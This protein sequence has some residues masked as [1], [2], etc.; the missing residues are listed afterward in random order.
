M[1]SVHDAIA[2]LNEMIACD[3]VAVEQLI[4]ARVPCNDNLAYHPTV[5][6][7][8]GPDG[9]QVGLLGV[10]NGIF[11]E[12]NP[13]PI[14]ADYQLVCS[15]NCGISGQEIDELGLKFSDICRCQ[16]GFIDCGDIIRFRVSPQASFTGVIGNP[17]D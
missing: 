10:L 4:E 17:D 13:V 11:Q 8:P 9:Y 16:E 1:K 14:I 7:W 6:V 12:G 2:L 5:Q 3:R 15:K